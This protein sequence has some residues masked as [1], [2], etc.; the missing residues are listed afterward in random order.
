[1]KIK[2]TPISILDLSLVREGFGFEQA[3]KDSVDYIRFAEKMGFLRFWV[4]EH[5]NA[6][7]IASS[8]TAVLIG[9]LA[10]KTD[11]IRVGSGGIMLPNHSPLQVA[12]AFGTLETMYPNRIDLGLGRAPGTDGATAAAL[13]R[14]REDAVGDYPNDVAEL[15]QYLGDENLQGN[16]KA[17][18]GVGTHVPIWIL[19]SSP[20]SAQLAAYYG[21][22]YAFASHFAPAYLET[23]M[24]IYRR[25]FKPSKYLNQPY[26]MPAAN[27][28]IAETEEEAQYQSTSYLQ[29]ARNI[30]LRQSSKLQKPVKNM[31]DIWEPA[32]KAAVQQMRKYSFVGTAE[33]VK[34][35]LEDM[36]AYTNA[37]E[38]MLTSYFYNPAD[39]EKSFRLLK[40]IA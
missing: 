25:E 36:I 1:M 29:M 6:K 34:S 18:P 16:I 26:F 23:A 40:E 21:L 15:I 14:N 27:V 19:G 3:I 24:E 32:V 5:H 11:S 30:V 35:D 37:D 31:D 39:R 9:H 38:L 7:G 20:Y 28:I 22:P 12:E 33:Q 10:E 8:A 13:R 17:Y 4:A 2:N